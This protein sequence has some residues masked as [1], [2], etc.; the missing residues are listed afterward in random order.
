MCGLIFQQHKSHIAETLLKQK[1]KFTQETVAE[2]GKLA[3]M[4]GGTNGTASMSAYGDGNF[5]L[6]Q[7][8][9]FNFRECLSK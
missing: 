7:F 8:A 6:L 2:D 9:L 1:H 4:N 3:E 5:S